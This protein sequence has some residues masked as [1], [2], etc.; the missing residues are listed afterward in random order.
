MLIATDNTTVVAYINQENSVRF[1]PF[2]DRLLS[3]CNLMQIVLKARHIPGHLNVI[4]D[5]LSHQR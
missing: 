1:V 4:A 5:K 3:G 2:Y